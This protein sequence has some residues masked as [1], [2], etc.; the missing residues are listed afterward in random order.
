MIDPSIL[1][2]PLDPTDPRHL[3]GTLLAWRRGNF[4]VRGPAD[5]SGNLKRVAGALEEPGPLLAANELG[6]DRDNLTEGGSTLLIVEDDVSFAKILLDLAREKGFKG[7]VALRGDTGLALA[8]K[9]QPDAITLD[10]KLPVVDGWTL[11][12]LLKQDPE[13]RHIPVQLISVKDDERDRGLRQGA[14]AFLTKPVTREVLAGAVD[15]ARAFIER[16]LKRVLVVEDNLMQRQL[17]MALVGSGDVQAVAV[18]TGEDALELLRGHHF[19]CMVL[20]VGLPGMTGFQVIDQ[21]RDELDLPDLPIIVHT[22][23][24]LTKE[25]E[26]GLARVTKAVIV[27]GPGSLEHLR[28]ELELF[29]HRASLRRRR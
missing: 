24:E 3:L 15:L 17:V 11:L 28:T 14:L 19:D 1:T 29:L 13:T 8:R 10:L 7:I 18:S 5:A 27:K 26:T 4:S 16:R 6:D 9:L 22:G 25:Q 23:R 2:G 12:H 20:D 21:V